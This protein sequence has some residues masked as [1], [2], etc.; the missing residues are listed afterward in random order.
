MTTEDK[1]PHRAKEPEVN[2]PFAQTLTSASVD[3]TQAQR[4]GI[5]ERVLQ[6]LGEPVDFLRVQVRPLWSHNYRVNVLVGGSSLSARIAYSYFVV[7]DEGGTV[8]RT[9]PQIAALR[10]SVHKTQDMDETRN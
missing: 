3:S 5:G 10:T 9:S 2:T 1:Q 8:L 7:A 4:A 6:A